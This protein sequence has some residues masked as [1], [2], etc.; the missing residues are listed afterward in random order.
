MTM[1][2]HI[3]IVAAVVGLAAPAH[4]DPTPTPDQDATFQRALAQDGI[5][6]NG[7]TKAEGLRVCR[8][9]EDGKTPMDAIHDLMQYGGYPFDVANHMSVD[10]RDAYCVDEFIKAEKAM[11]PGVPRGE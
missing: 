4:A 5:P 1:K 10:A 8:Q 7:I 11:A 2:Q 6:F 9:I 3:A